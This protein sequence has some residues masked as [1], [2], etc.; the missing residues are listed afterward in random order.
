MFSYEQADKTLT[1]FL[2]TIVPNS[3]VIITNDRAV[4][5]SNN[6]NL[7][8]IHNI[9]T[10][11]YINRLEEYTTIE[12]DLIISSN[13][14]YH[15]HDDIKF[16]YKGLCHSSSYEEWKKENTDNVI[17]GYALINNTWYYHSWGTKNNKIIEYQAPFE[18]YIGYVRFE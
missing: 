7:S 6:V 5:D 14:I 1:K 11:E 13:I 18:I 2:Q 17:T 4:L 9:T 10:D 15:K 16:Q 8:F 12:V 3:K